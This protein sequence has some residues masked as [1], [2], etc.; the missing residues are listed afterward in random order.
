MVQLMNTWWWWCSRPN[1]FTWYFCHFC[2]HKMV[3]SYILDWFVH[4]FTWWP[5]LLLL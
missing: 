5:W 1:L 4:K 2:C 3:E